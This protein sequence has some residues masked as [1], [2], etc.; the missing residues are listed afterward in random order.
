MIRTYPVMNLGQG[1]PS[2]VD[3]SIAAF[4]KTISRLEDLAR[5]L[6]GSPRLVIFRK[7]LECRDAAEEMRGIPEDVLSRAEP[8]V[9]ACIQDL[10]KQIDDE[11]A[12]LQT[13][14]SKTAVTPSGT[15]AWPFV[16]GG[17]VA[18]GIA[19]FLAT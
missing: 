15:P 8:D 19:I 5:Q 2:K 17:A 9:N 10:K 11:I 6:P 13:P 7:A 16:A 18:I 12:S 3:E 1:G 14:V 4:G